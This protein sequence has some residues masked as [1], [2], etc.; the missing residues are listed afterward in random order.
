M[1]LIIQ[2][3]TG[4]NSS[5]LDFSMSLT[6]WLSYRLLLDVHLVVGDLNVDLLVIL[7]ISHNKGTRVKVLWD[8]LVKWSFNRFFLPFLNTSGLNSFQL[9]QTVT[10]DGKS[11]EDDVSSTDEQGAVVRK[12]TASQ[13]KKHL[14]LLANEL[15]D[16]SFNHWSSSSDSSCS[17][18]DVKQNMLN[19][20]Q[21]HA[22]LKGFVS[23]N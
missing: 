3:S 14:A 18:E 8:L 20:T 6:D 13:S 10:G 5:K 16:K 1:V 22:D 15:A 4:K 11:Q 2:T 19:G 21:P 7:L 12:L 9:L 17:L 23:M